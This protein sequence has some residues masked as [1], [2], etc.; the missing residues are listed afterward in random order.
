ML[1]LLGRVGQEEPPNNESINDS[2]LDLAVYA[3]LYYSY[4]M[5]D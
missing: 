3:L 4:F 2:R 1:I 5:E